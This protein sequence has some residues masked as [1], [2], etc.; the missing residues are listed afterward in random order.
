MNPYR[1]QFSDYCSVVLVTGTDVM[2]ASLLE[3]LFNFGLKTASHCFLLL[4]ILS[5]YPQAKH[6][7]YNHSNLDSDSSIENWLKGRYYS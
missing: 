2:L 5:V 3:K 1:N 7:H 4:Q 6:K